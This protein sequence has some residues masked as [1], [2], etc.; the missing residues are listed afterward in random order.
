MKGEGEESGDFCLFCVKEKKFLVLK[1][2]SYFE[3]SVWMKFSTSAL[4]EYEKEARS[5][6]NFELPLDSFLRVL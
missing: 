4:R 6:L 1:S 3:H 2:F 5:F